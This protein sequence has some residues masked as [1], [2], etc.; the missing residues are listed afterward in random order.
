[1]P[2]F[3]VVFLVGARL[4]RTDLE[5]LQRLPLAINCERQWLAERKR[6]YGPNRSVRGGALQ[7]KK[8]GDVRRPGEIEQ[9]RWR[10][11][12]LHDSEPP[13]RIL[14]VRNLVQKQMCLA[15]EN[16]QDAGFL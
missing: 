7:R 5:L 8:G 3:Q 2:V 14:I 13:K 4:P 10:S 15:F 11:V 1:M 12:V 6:A 16:S 9:A